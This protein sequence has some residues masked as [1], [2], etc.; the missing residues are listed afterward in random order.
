MAYLVKIG[1]SQ[2]IRIPKPLI[3]QAH[4]EGKELQ[5]QVVNGGLFIAPIKTTRQGWK[6]SIE[7]IIALQGAEVIDQQWLDA[8]LIAD[9]ELEW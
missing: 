6:K 1:N 9:D 4:L 2:G 8:D 7:E 3:E 5:L